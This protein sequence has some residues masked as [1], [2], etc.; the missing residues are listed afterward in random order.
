MGSIF[1]G[2]VLLFS[3]MATASA[4]QSV[5]NSQVIS[6]KAGIYQGQEWV[7]IEFS[8]LSGVPSCPVDNT[9]RLTLDPTTGYGKAMLSLAMQAKAAGTLVTAS[10][11]GTCRID[12]IEDLKFL[13]LN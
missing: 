5:S 13:Q 6:I 7:A 12:G 9:H 8:N 2:V 11:N 1:I 10:G 4:S 3:Y